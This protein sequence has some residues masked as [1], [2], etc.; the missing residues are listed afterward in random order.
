MRRGRSKK[1]P[2]LRHAWECAAPMKA[3][4]TIATRR[5]GGAVGSGVVVIYVLLAGPSVD[6][7]L[8]IRHRLKLG[9]SGRTVREF[10]PELGH[11]SRLLTVQTARGH[12]AVAP[13]NTSRES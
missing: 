5:A 2:A 1:R 10:L 3:W 12:G 6:V 8:F 11:K 7:S 9:A 4:P 13:T